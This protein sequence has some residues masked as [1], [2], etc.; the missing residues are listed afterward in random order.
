MGCLV[1]VLELKLQ[2]VQNILKWNQWL[3]QQFLGFSHEHSSLVLN[4]Q[5]PSTGHVSFQ[6]QL[7]FDVFFHATVRYGKDDVVVTEFVTFFSKITEIG[8][9]RRNCIQMS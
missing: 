7:V 8:I 5:N 9:W 3:K 6:C 4:V 2:N 1:F